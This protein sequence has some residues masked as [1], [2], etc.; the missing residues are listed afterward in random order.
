MTAAALASLAALL[1]DRTRV[2][3][4]LALLDGRAWTAGEL[5]RHAG[6]TASTASGHLDR[7]IAGGLLA[8]ERAGRHRYVRLADPDVAQLLED[9]VVRLDPAPG[10]VASL[11][12]ANRS[13]ALARA[14]TCYDHLAGQLGVAIA[15]A[16]TRRGY[17]H[18]K[19]GFA[20]TDAGVDWLTGTLGVDAGALHR[21]RRPVARGCLDWTERRPHLAGSAGR[22]ICQRL[23]DRRWVERLSGTR[24]VQVTPAGRAAL[25]DMFGQPFSATI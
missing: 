1:A 24:A 12:A 19:H 10:P 2:E 21:T 6:V 7:L 25:A 3:I 16:L 14:R 20:L 4:C 8:E 13:A 18:Q 23:L 22:E 11:R 17:L 9:L 5:A 15:D